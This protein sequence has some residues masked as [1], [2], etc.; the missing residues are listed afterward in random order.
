MVLV[1]QGARAN[2]GFCVGSCE[3]YSASEDCRERPELGMGGLLF[4]GSNFAPDGK[5][6]TFLGGEVH[7]GDSLFL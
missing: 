5:M 2:A 4:C 7:V 3:A 6:A 1:Q